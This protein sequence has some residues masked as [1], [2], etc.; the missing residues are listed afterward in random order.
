ME[1]IKIEN[2]KKCGSKSLS[3]KTIEDG[4][5]KHF[6]SLFYFI[7]IATFLNIKN[8]FLEQMKILKFVF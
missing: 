3:S 1:N 8:K 4:I 7:K 6:F 2:Y 5:E